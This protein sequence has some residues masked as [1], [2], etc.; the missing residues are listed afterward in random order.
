MASALGFDTR[1]SDAANRTFSLAVLVSIVA[2]AV[3]LLV[4]FPQF[5]DTSK[6]PAIAPGP[7]V[8][9]LVQT[10]PPAPP[11]PPKPEAAEPAPPPPVAKPEPPPPP[12]V[13]K[14]APPPKPIPVVK[15][16]PKPVPVA[17]P[18]PVAR[19]ASEA[20]PEP[21]PAPS[22]EP[23]RPAA[24]AP[25]ET[26]S[27]A[28][29]APATSAPPGPVAKVDPQPAAPPA[30]A[31][32]LAQYRLAIITSAKRYKRYPR[33]AMDN[34][35]E[36]RVEV[37]MVVGANGMIASISI[38][39]GTGHDILDKQALDMIRKAKPLT[40]I[41][42]ALRGKEFTVDIPVIFSLKEPDA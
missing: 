40:P 26:A 5:R 30:D 32:T 16:E 10:K 12:P 25:S 2:H 34:N 6:R 35:W 17:K 19:P 1:A 21:R 38:K 42:S 33:V 31:A 28:P 14:P 9:R 24:P 23:P 4:A 8:A 15:P 37:R 22:P 13:V 39:T 20:K 7:I 41:P 11:A 27:A 29:A 3:L 18:A 36:G